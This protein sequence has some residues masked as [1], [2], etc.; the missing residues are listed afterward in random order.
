M[1]NITKAREVLAVIRENQHRLNMGMWATGPVDPDAQ[2]WSECRTAFCYA[3][4]LCALDGLRPVCDFNGMATGGFRNQAGEFVEAWVHAAD[5]LDIDFRAA[6]AIFMREDIT[7]VDDLEWIVETVLSGNWKYCGECDGDGCAEC[8]N[9]GILR[10]E[11]TV[12]V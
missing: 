9:R 8:D 2:H 11:E 1:A 7:S 12:D 5:Q 6:D 3:G 4:W 10:S